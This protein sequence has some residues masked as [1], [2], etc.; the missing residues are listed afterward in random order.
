MQCWGAGCVER[1]VGGVRLPGHVRRVF[2][3][4][5]ADLR[6]QL[7]G[8]LPR[9]SQQNNNM[10]RGPR[11][12]VVQLV[13]LVGLLR[14]NLRDR[15]GHSHAHVPRVLGR[16]W[17]GGRQRRRRRHCRKALLQRTCCRVECMEHLRLQCGRLRRRC[18]SANT[19]V[20]QQLPWSAGGEEGGVADTHL[21]GTFEF[22]LSIHFSCSGICPGSAVEANTTACVVGPAAEVG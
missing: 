12:G 1:L 14:A 18:S 7:L 22:S 2:A 10:H 21:P 6:A 15:N 4:A 16:V 20:Q 3:G 19:H 9:G 5:H 8:H 11:E 13:R 17:R